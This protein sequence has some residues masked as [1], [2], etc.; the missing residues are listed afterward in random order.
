MRKLMLSLTLVASMTAPAPAGEIYQ[1]F[2]SPNG[3]QVKPEVKQV[4][5]EACE[6]EWPSDYRMQLYCQNNQKTAAEQLAKL[7]IMI[8]Q[9]ADTKAAQVARKIFKYCRSEWPTDYH[10]TNYCV[11]NQIEA[12]NKLQDDK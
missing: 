9:K 6:K 10:M 2:M 11:K 7:E 12:Y 3:S 8:E 5:A 4:Y 1:G